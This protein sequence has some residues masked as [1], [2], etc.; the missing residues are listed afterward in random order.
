MEIARESIFISSLRSFCK[1]FFSVIGLCVSL[2][3]VATV[4]SIF[5]SPY[6]PDEKTSLTILPD[7]QGNQEML[8]FSSPV[9]L[10]IN[11]DG[12]IGMPNQITGETI[13]NILLDS[14]KGILHNNRVKA[15]LLY[16]NTPGGTVTDSDTIYRELKEYKAKYNTPVYAYI[17]GMCASGGMYVASAADKSFASPPSVI[18]SVGVIYG[19][20]FNFSDAMAK[21]GIQSKTITEGL[22]KDSLNPF[23]PWRPDEDASFK[24]VMAFLYNRFVNIVTEARPRLD[25]EKLISEYGAKIFDGPDAQQLGY[26]DVADSN[27]QSALLALV[28]EA[29]IDPAKPY[30]V[31]QLSPKHDFLEALAKS[32]LLKGKVEHI[33]NLGDRARPELRDQFSYLFAP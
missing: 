4:Y 3:L 24:T 6:A 8:S 29:K 17:D 9:V 22:D 31:I 7:L 12:V 10:R 11:I 15:I 20:L 25:K 27:Y 2:F 18:G 19:P 30:Q 32:E 21:V 33:L 1:I 13:Q 28:Q 5:S 14:R 16:M 23:R 26:I